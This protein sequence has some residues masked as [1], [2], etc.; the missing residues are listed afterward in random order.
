M[1]AVIPRPLLV[2]LVLALPALPLVAGLPAHPKALAVLNN[3]AHAVVFG[4]LAPVI[5]RLLGPRLSW[6]HWMPYAVAFTAAVAVGAA[7]EL[8]QPSLGREAELRDVW[9]D[10]LGAVAGLAFV[11]LCRPAG[12]W[13]AG[14]ILAVVLTA[15]ACPV[16]ET[17]LAYR[18]R[19]RQAPAL[20]ELT[21]RLDWKFIW[22]H[23]FETSTVA[24]PAAWRRQNDPQSLEL[25]IGTDSWRV[26]A[27]LEP[28]PDWRPYQSLLIDLTN[29]EP[30]PL[31]L[32]LRVHDVPHDNQ[33]KD[34]FNRHIQ[35]PPRTR[36]VIAI[37]LA[38]IETAPSR[39][40]LDLSRVAAVMI[41]T[42]GDRELSNR[43]FYVTR[44]WLEPSS[45]EDTKSSS[46]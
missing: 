45:I 46:E 42:R 24:L 29:P 17:A 10:A 8:I 20:L 43:R 3:T 26:L 32:T 40:L 41:F 12:H 16:L 38:D 44:I 33:V 27:L 11:A 39:R 31:S 34:R 37:S 14:W 35:I 1:P 36:H 18:E 2:V 9:S 25:R 6:P 4:V 21:S 30:K 22:T 28:F 13:I 19:S 7:I 23:G 15:V 5:L